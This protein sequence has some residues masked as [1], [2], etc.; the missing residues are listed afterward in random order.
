VSLS[1]SEASFENYNAALT[2]GESGAS[3]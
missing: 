2:L 1:F 3:S